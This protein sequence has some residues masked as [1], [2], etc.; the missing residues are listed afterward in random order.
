M[1]NRTQ[2]SA[3]RFTISQTHATIE[4]IGS[5]GT[6]GARKPRGRSGRVRRSTT[7]PAETSTNANR[8]PTL[9]ISSSLLIGNTDAVRATTTATSTVIRTGV[10][11][12]PVLASGRGSSPS[13]A[14][15]N[16]TRHCPSIRTITTVVNPANAPTAIILLA[17]CTPLAVNAVDRL[18]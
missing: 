9:T 13:G 11:C 4:A 12:V 10:P 7:T 17:Q 5:A 1:A 14:I 6:H 16:N 8:V 3:V 18:A 15:A 2:V